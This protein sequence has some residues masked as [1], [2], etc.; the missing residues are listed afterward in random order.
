MNDQTNYIVIKAMTMLIEKSKPIQNYMLLKWANQWIE[1][2][3]W[4]DDFIS[5]KLLKMHNAMKNDLLKLTTE[6]Q[7]YKNACDE[8][9]EITSLLF[10]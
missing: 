10:S 5:N 6:K 2:N 1:E 8:Y 4:K 7:I 3:E 9:A